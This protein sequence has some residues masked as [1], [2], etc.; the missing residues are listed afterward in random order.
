M[1]HSSNSAAGVQTGRESSGLLSSLR[2][3]IRSGELAPG[4]FLPTVRRLSREAG[5]AHGTAWRALKA[6]EAE[7]L[8]EARPRRGY[9]VITKRAI[10]SASGTVAYVID[11]HN[12]LVSWDLLYRELLA[13]LENCAAIGEIKLLK[14]IMNAGEEDLV[15]ERLESS[16]L[17]GIVLDSMNDKLLRWAASSGLPA[18]VVDDWRPGLGFDSVIQGNYEG[19]GL[20]A[21]HLLEN[22]C[23]R[24]AWLGHLGNHHG[25]ARYGGVRAAVSAAGAELCRDVSCGLSPEET[26]RAARRILSGPNR[27]DGIVALWH[28]AAAAAVRVARSMR[29]KIGR[30]LRVVGWCCAEIYEEGYLPL[31]EDGP[32]P[33]AVTWSVKSMA[34]MALARIDQ[35]RRASDLPPSCT[36]LPVELKT[37]PGSK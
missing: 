30:D 11:Q 37:H 17:D 28:P 33:P 31:F 15:V 21:G 35:R 12:I 14:L 18:V 27:P 6:L 1:P 26:T 25:R 9:R 3:R 24:I 16:Q 22:G 10:T 2:T 19:G 23:E 36:M 7:G 8:V 34:E 13:K 20:A 32:V 5:V 29:L 4:D